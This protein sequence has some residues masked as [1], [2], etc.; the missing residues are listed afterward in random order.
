M[1]VKVI[2]IVIVMD[3]VFERRRPLRIEQ[4]PVIAP[5]R[6]AVHVPTVPVEKRR[7]RVTH[8]AHRNRRTG[9]RSR[10]QPA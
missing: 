10:A 9:V 7:R 5:V 8:R 1:P 6:M 4:M 3:V 2:V